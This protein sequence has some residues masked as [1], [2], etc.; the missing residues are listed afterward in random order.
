[1]PIDR[2]AVQVRLKQF[3]FSGLFTQEL[4][5]PA[6]LR[7]RLGTP[8]QLVALGNLELLAPQNM[9]TPVRRQIFQAPQPNLNP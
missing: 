2:K 4:G 7:Q 1:M 8:F 9:D 6:R 5:Y 3:D